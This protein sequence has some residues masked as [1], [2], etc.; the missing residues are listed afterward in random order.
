MKRIISLILVIFVWSSMCCTSLAEEVL[1]TSVEWNQLS[2]KQA[3]K[4]IQ[5]QLISRKYL[6]GKADGSVGAQ[7]TSAI[8]KNKALNGI[9]PISNEINY[10][11]YKSL[12]GYDDIGYMTTKLSS[13]TYE[14][15]QYTIEAADE[16]GDY[17]DEITYAL[18]EYEQLKRQGKT[19][20]KKFYE[21]E[22]LLVPKGYD[23]DVYVKALKKYFTTNDDGIWAFSKA[24]SKHDKTTIEYSERDGYT[25]YAYKIYVVNTICLISELSFEHTIA[26]LGKMLDACTEYA[27]NAFA[28]SWT[29]TIKA[30]VDATMSN[31]K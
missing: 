22:R 9:A 6:Y 2:N 18:K 7:T 21:L 12:Y 27:P 1:L 29:P 26:V 30:K 13:D 16:R 14:F 19:G 10:A 25:I 15:W 17:Y 31:K 20:T 28:N 3:I 5:E 8:V 4:I 11:L 24:I 23:V